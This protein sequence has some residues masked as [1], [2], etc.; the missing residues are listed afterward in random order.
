MRV[1]EGYVYDDW[2][3]SEKSRSKMAAKWPELDLPW[4]DLAAKAFA[5]A[6]AN[7]GSN[8]DGFVD[9]RDDIRAVSFASAKLLQALHGC[10]FPARHSLGRLKSG[11]AQTALY[12]HSVA[13]VTAFIDATGQLAKA[14]EDVDARSLPHPMPE[15]IIASTAAS[16]CGPTVGQKL[17]YGPSFSDHHDA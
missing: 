5:S 2:T 11:N 7:K 4:I 12:E 3:L 17:Q 16:I 8:R 9:W 10:A 15:L 1:E 13:V 14:T 6:W